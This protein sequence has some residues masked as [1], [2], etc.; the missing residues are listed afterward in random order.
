[1]GGHAIDIVW[2]STQYR[3]FTRREG[4]S[5]GV[6]TC[7]AV[8]RPRRRK[9]TGGVLIRPQE[10]N[11]LLMQ[12]IDNAPFMGQNHIQHRIHVLQEQPLTPT[13]VKLV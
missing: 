11:L 1:M 4:L 5:G 6:A 13:L 10:D 8:Q 3:V 12:I 7:L 2:N 9:H